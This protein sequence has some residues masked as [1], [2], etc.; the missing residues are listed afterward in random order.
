MM[1][2]MSRYTQRDWDR[3]VGW[4]KVPEEYMMPSSE[5]L[6]IQRILQ[7]ELDRME[8]LNKGLYT[9]QEVIIRNWLMKRIEE[10]QN[11]KSNNK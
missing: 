7:N 9:D 6:M 5:D 3:V 8:V 1:M 4:G 11:G 2:T 10:V